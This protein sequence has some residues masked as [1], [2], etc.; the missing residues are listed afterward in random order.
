MD[1]DNGDYKQEVK[2]S[3]RELPRPRHNVKR[4]T[5]PFIDAQ[6][7]VDG[8]ASGNDGTDDLNN[9]LNRSIVADDIAF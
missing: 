8:D 7:G 4:R 9:D 5:N 1:I 2:D 6:A 3:E